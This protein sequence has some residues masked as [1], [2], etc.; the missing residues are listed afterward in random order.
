M[1][2]EGQLL[3]RC[4]VEGAGKQI[5]CLG[6]RTSPSF[7]VAANHELA[8]PSGQ[9]P[10]AGG[11]RNVSTQRTIEVYESSHCR[12]Q[13]HERIADN[14]TE[15]WFLIQTQVS[16]SVNGQTHRRRHCIGGHSV[17][18]RVVVCA[19]W[20]RYYAQTPLPRFVVDL[21]NCCVYNG[22]T[23]KRGTVVPALSIDFKILQGILNLSC[24]LWPPSSGIHPPFVVHPH[25]VFILYFC[26][27]IMK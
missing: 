19:I 5:N 3:L 8:P 11:I 1:R 20:L 2:Q 23:A 17:H 25:F 7:I 27:P 13:V 6:R 10:L 15:Y 18:L 21:S 14:W 24:R 22:A 12:F 26:C 16:I 4:R 9:H